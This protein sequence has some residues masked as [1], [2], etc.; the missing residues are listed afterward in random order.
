MSVR[1]FNF[2]YIDCLLILI[3]ICLAANKEMVPRKDYDDYSKFINESFLSRK[4]VFN[5]KPHSVWC[6][7]ITV[8][9]ARMY[10][11]ETCFVREL[12]ISQL[13]TRGC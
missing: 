13:L 3:L 1:R 4:Y 11:I 10:F 9:H 12:E 6:L 5:F 8:C 2:K 7:T